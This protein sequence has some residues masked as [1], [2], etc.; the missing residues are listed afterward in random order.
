MQL[1]AERLAER[2]PTRGFAVP[3][4]SLEELS[5]LTR[6]R[7]HN[8]TLALSLAIERGGLEWET[9][10][11]S[12]LHRLRSTHRRTSEDPEH[13]TE[14]W[15]S[16]HR[17]FH[18]SLLSGCQIPL[19]LDLARTMFDSME[20][21]RRWSAPSEAASHRDVDAEHAALVEAT[22]ARDSVSALQLLDD[23][24]STTLQVILESGLVSA[25]VI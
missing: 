1:S 11:L 9:E 24:Y 18:L 20:L 12:A 10:V 7:I 3:Q 23:H 16:R 14:E 21:Y 2:R 4:L 22:L 19:L 8:D 5:D 6:V 25:T 15:S 17:E 13:T